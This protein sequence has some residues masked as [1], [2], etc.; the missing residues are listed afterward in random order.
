MVS[1]AEMYTTYTIVEYIRYKK[2][3]SQLRIN[4]KFYKPGF[5]K[6]YV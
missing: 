3:N 6:F 2:G 4:I 5:V 1:V